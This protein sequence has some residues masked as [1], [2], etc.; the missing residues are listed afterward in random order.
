M[1][2]LISVLLLSLPLTAL[3][4]AEKFGA[5]LSGAPK[6]A[7]QDLMANPDAW[8]GKIVRTEGPV[9]AVCSQRSGVEIARPRR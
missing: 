2:R 4:G 5:P 8:A 9:S 3:A 6:V 1:R 7:L